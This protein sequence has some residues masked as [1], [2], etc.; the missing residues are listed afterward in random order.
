MRTVPTSRVTGRSTHVAHLLVSA[1][2][3]A[4][5]AIG[6]GN[7]GESPLKTAVLPEQLECQAKT[8]MKQS[9]EAGIVL[10]RSPDD[11]TEGPQQSLVNRG[12][13]RDITNALPREE[14]TGTE[15]GA[16]FDF[17]LSA[18]ARCP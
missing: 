16:T 6:F 10:N 12:R 1:Q 3:S 7:V 17:A 11:P 9:V 8:A 13:R 18:P 15:S 2:H 4:I 14:H 5:F